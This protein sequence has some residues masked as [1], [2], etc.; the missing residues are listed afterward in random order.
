MKKSKKILALLAIATLNFQFLTFQSFAQPGSLDLTF[1]TG[2]IVTTTIGNGDDYGISVAIQNDGKMIVA[3][4]SNNG[5]NNDFAL[6]RYNSDGTLDNAFGINGKVLLAIGN[7][8]EC[9]QS[10][11]IQS[12]GKILVAGSSNNGANDDFALVRYKSNGTLDSTFGTGGIVITAFGSAADNGYSVVIQIDGKIVVV[13]STKNGTPTHFALVRYNSDGTLDNTF[14]TSGKVITPVGIYYFDSAYSVAIQ[15]DGKI[16][17]SGTS[18]NIFALVR[19]NSDGSLDNTFGTGGKV[20]TNV[21]PGGIQIGYSVAIQIDG[22]IVASGFKNNGN[23]NSSIFVVRYNNIGILDNT[24]GTG[25]IVI[26]TFG[27][28]DLAFSVA[29]QSDGKIVVA[30]YGNNGGGINYDIALLR[31]NN[32]GSLDN[33]FGTGGKVTTAIGSSYDKAYSVA[34]QSDG[35]IVVAGASM[36][37]SSVDFAITRYNAISVPPSNDDCLSAI[38]ITQTTTC[39]PTNGTTILATQS[40][41]AITCGGSAGIA[42]DDVW[43]KFVA[44]TSNPTITVVGSSSFNA[45]VDLRSGTCNGINIS[46]ADATL[47]GGIE[48]INTTGLT[49]GSTYYI[50]VYSFGTGSFTEGAFTICV[51]DGVPQPPVNDEC[52]GAIS[53]TQTAT[54]NPTNGTTIN[55]TQSIAGLLCAGFTGTADDDVWYK[56]V[57]TTSNQTITV[58]GFSSFDAVVD[59]RSGACNGTNINC[60]DAVYAGGTEIINSTGLAIGS[61]YYIRVYSY[62]PG[63]S[64]QGT[65]TICVFNAVTTGIEQTNE[66]IQDFSLYPNPAKNDLIIETKNT[67]SKHHFEIINS[68]GTLVYSDVI[69]NKRTVD[70]SSLSNGI[71]IVKLFTGE[72]TIIKKFTKQ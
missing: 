67:N 61:T 55:A 35:K 52:S 46:C 27:A 71:Y 3:G 12:D 24:F 44:T 64:Y 2:G 8:D 50:R 49:I 14:G 18:D 68:V 28:D 37:G 36:I 42:D 22:K 33:T 4:C 10:I 45:V 53:L 62:D 32:D 69:D 23:G 65:F 47:D 59:L 72:S 15:S 43:Y 1:G 7:G 70:I 56:F 38:N 41:A 9:G 54:C 31:Y 48:T 26:T 13:G 39:S 16:V 11:V 20:T 57:A 40:I 51:V 63:A 17:V 29:L 66:I 58:S 6:V 5:A 30:G 60:A 34:L 25:G 19:F 21:G